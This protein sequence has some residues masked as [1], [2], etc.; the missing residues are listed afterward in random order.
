MYGDMFMVFYGRVCG[1]G[2]CVVPWDNTILPQEYSDLSIVNIVS[3]NI[4][5]V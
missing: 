4:S 1:V 3:G 2:K 5:M